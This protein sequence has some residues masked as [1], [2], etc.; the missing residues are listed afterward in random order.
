MIY[1]VVALGDWLEAP[2]RP[3]AP[4]S[5]PDD[6]FVHCSPDAATTLAVC[7]AFY[8]DSP[9]PLVAL[10]IDEDRLGVPIRWEAADPAPPPGVDPDTRFPHVYGPIA[11]AAVGAV[12]RVE[13]DA[14]GRA[15]SLT[16]V[17]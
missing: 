4:G 10:C 1:H 6:G 13:R 12:L 11:R 3:Y 14:A 5:L 16:P 15:L 17:D 9:D 7:N 2:D 8:R